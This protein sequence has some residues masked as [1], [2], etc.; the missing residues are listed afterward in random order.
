MH[1]N[2]MLTVTLRRKV[3]KSEKNKTTEVKWNTVKLTNE[4]DIRSKYADNLNKTL[5][6]RFKN[7]IDIGLDWLHTAGTA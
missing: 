3:R 1:I 2:L 7:T 6:E 5:K 4:Y